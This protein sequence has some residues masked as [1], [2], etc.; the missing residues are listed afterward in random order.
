MNYEL[1]LNN[2]VELW[3]K[4]KSEPVFT[5]SVIGENFYEFDLEVPRLSDSSDIIPITISEKLFNKEDLK[6]DSIFALNG[7]FR[8]YNKL[9]ENKSKL[10][11][12]VFV[13][14]VIDVNT[15]KNPNIINLK[16]YLCKEPVFRTTPFKR[17]ICDILLAVNR[18]YNK[19]DYIPCIAWGRN[20][21]FVKNLPVGTKLNIEGRIQSRIYQKKLSDDEIVNKTAYEISISKI[22]IIEKEEIITSVELERLKQ[23][24][25]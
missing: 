24:A 12:T 23:N 2:S 15:D 22:D 9:V 7:Q 14:E 25:D 21:R 8:S 19:S 11:L 6:V 17:E 1:L 3:G 18:A 10:M 20:A 5:H 13:R 16:G 4:V